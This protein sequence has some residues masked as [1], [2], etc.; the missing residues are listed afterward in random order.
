MIYERVSITVPLNLRSYLIFFVA[1][2]MYSFE[3]RLLYIHT[4]MCACVLVFWY[5]ILLI[6]FMFTNVSLNAFFHACL[7]NQHHSNKT[8]TLN[9]LEH[10]CAFC[11]LRRLGLCGLFCAIY[12]H[13]LY[14]KII[15]MN[16]DKRQ[17][18]NIDDEICLRCVQWRVYSKNILCLRNG[19]NKVYKL[20]GLGAF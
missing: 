2:A 20:S 4:R 19:M 10:L 7:C 16:Y 8:W 12:M 6:V 1:V 14:N 18:Y 3:N 17:M 13:V 9:D 5:C 15:L 11:M